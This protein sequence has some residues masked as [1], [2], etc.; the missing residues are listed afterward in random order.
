MASLMWSEIQ[1]QPETLRRL[2]SEGWE[3]AKT[4]AQAIRDYEP[5]YVLMAARGTSDNA[6]RYGQYLLGAHNRLAVGLATPSL[7]TVYEAPPRLPG[8][9]VVGLSQSGQSPDVAEVVENA[10]SQGALTIGITNYPESRLGQAAEHVLA[11]RAGD[12][13]SVPATK[14]YTAQVLAVAMLSAALGNE[15]RAG[16]EAVPGLASAALEL[17]AAIE[18]LAQ[19]YRDAER[20]VV[21]GRGYN[22][23]TAFEIAIK[24]QEA[25]YLTALPYSSADFQHGPLSMVAP[26]L[27]VLV[28]AP[29]GRVRAELL[30]LARNLREWG[31]SVIVF[32]DGPAPDWLPADHFVPMPAG[33]P[34]TL[35]I[36]PLAVA[37][38]LL[39][40]SVAQARGLD[41][42]R[43][44]FL[45]KVTSTF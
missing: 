15:D 32:G 35:S 17:E 42:D 23:G 9:L 3:Q 33:Q 39:A 40:H 4:A 25:A 18:P 27:P 37:G 36:F 2:L 30:E 31:A 7:F 38:Q 45:H 26:S 14:T 43:P 12:E 20:M 5:N 22:F 34:E 13:R 6:A 8:A 16:L 24:L 29:S 28:L 11:L 10:R 44:R 41:P 1:E 21:I 19:A